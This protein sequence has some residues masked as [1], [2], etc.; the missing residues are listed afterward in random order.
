METRVKLEAALGK[1]VK[2]RLGRFRRRNTL[3]LQ[4]RHPG[5]RQQT[6]R[7]E[8]EMRVID[9]QIL[10]RIGLEGSFQREALP[11][12]GASTGAASIIASKSRSSA[13][14]GPGS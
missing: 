2:Q 3:L 6:H 7:P 9:Q 13:N 14:S 8:E 5:Q 12:S 11:A 10:L 4:P 1:Q